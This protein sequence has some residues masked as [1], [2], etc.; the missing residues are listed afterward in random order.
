[1]AHPTIVTFAS[2]A[3]IP[4]VQNWIKHVDA[5][6]VRAPVKIVA[7]DATTRDA[8]SA[9]RVAY[10]PC[11]V[12]NLADLWTFRIR[13][14]HD[15]LQ[16]GPGLVHSD[17]DAVWLRD[18]LPTIADCASDIV[19][20]QGT[21]WPP[22]VHTKRGLVLC[23]GLYHL[24]NTTR[25]HSFMTQLEARVAHDGD[26]QVSVNRLLDESGLEWVVED[27]YTIPV[28]GT[29]FIASRRTIRSSGG[30][31]WGSVA[32]LPHHLF[33]RQ[34]E[35]LDPNVIVAHP[36]S[37]KTCVDKIKTLKRLGLWM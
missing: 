26:D 29:D 22:D 33:P 11:D 25:G 19:F 6:D 36:I 17:A 32:V 12:S 31:V 34:V 13:V 18:P 28:K 1:M 37:H 27:P 23:C 3:Y 30:G 9:A 4:V 15:L 35:S 10:R 14:L 24:S 8:F 21:I 20:S 7:L 5:L 2:E 16:E